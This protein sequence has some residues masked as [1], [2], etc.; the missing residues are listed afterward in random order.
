MLI[1]QQNTYGPQ[2]MTYHNDK[3]LPEVKTIYHG[4]R[5]ATCKIVVQWT[6]LSTSVSAVQCV[7]NLKN[8]IVMV[9]LVSVQRTK[10]NTLGDDVTC[11]SNR[12]MF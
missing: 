9:K 1:Q 6:I 2:T 5:S 11:G 7:I 3:S 12:Q 8:I 4:P 10:A